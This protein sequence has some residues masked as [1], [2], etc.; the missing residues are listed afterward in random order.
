LP[1]ARSRSARCCATCPRASWTP[2][3]AGGHDG[4]RAAHRAGRQPARRR[5]RDRE[6]LRYGLRVHRL[7]FSSSRA[8]TGAARSRTC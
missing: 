3:R 6:H 2:V 1:T 7:S 4:A 8:R 5:L